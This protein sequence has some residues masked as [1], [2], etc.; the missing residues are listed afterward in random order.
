MKP[1]VNLGKF[2]PFIPM[3]HKKTPHC[4]LKAIKL[5]LRAG[6]ARAE[7]TNAILSP[8]RTKGTDG[9]APLGPHSTAP[10]SQKPYAK[11]MPGT[12]F[13]SPG[14]FVHLGTIINTQHPLETSYGNET[15][16]QNKKRGTGNGEKDKQD[17]DKDRHRVQAVYQESGHW[18]SHLNDLL[19]LLVVG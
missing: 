9:S 8:A 17:W 14:K 2:F 4:A 11:N 13:Y 7:T 16:Y 10:P 15:T 5:W 1:V 3:Y 18:S 12:V 19:D 6:S